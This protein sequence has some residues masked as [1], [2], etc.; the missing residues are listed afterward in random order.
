[1]DKRKKR[2]DP[3]LKYNVTL[4]YSLAQ[5]HI[6]EAIVNHVKTRL[7]FSWMWGWVGFEPMVMCG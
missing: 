7:L 2:Q 1:M 3:R 6:K 5:A 4:T